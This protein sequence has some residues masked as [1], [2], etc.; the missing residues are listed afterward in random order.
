[1]FLAFTQRLLSKIQK[2]R[3]RHKAWAED[4]IGSRDVVIVAHGHFNRCF[5]ARWLNAS[6]DFGDVPTENVEISC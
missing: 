6:L 3:Q 2:V 4:G 5:V 1:V